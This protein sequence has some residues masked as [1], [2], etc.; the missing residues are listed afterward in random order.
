M[1][2]D[3]SQAGLL[4]IDVQEKLLAAMPTT[5]AAECLKNVELLADLVGEMGGPI[6]YTE[7]YPRGLGATVPSLRA[8]LGDAQRIEKISFSC[9]GESDFLE[10]VVPELP[11][12]LIVVGMEAHV[13]VLLTIF[14]LV[15]EYERE[16]Q[17]PAVFVPLDAVCSRKKGH[18]QNGLDQM[19]EF[20]A[21]ITNT[22]SLAYQAIGEA[23]TERFKRYAPRLR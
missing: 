4:I 20:G 18:W 6:F 17:A 23:G 21:I 14:D 15:A 2:P 9:L 10:R 7:Q 16:D 3:F 12:Y 5:V 13:C 1:I 19:A 11:D 22:E 8:R